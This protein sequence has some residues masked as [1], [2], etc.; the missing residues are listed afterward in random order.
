MIKKYLKGELTNIF[1]KKCGYWMARVHADKV[2]EEWI[3]LDCIKK[4]VK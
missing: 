1:C 4:G 3:C 2:G